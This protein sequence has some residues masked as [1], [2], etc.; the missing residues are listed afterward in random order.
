MT[1]WRRFRRLRPEAQ[2]AAWL[3]LALVYT[4][5]LVLLLGGGDSSGDGP[6]D[7]RASWSAQEKRAVA[8]IESAPDKKPEVGDVPAFRRPVVQKADCKDSTCSIVYAT[9]LPGNGRIVEDQQAMLARI[10]RD[11]SLDE[12]TLR[13]VRAGQVA[14]GKGLK[15]VEE[16]PAGMLILETDCK[17]TDDA[18]R[19]ADEQRTLAK[20]PAL[21]STRINSNVGQAQRDVRGNAAPEAQD[22][23]GVSGGG[24]EGVIEGQR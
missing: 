18:R 19:L 15:Q 13:V 23:P 17:R 8:A 4:V 16:T 22:A 24:G 21:C 5:G 20:V 14:P 10:Y 3:T 9:G 12:V 7:P 11:R 1:L 6:E 2:V